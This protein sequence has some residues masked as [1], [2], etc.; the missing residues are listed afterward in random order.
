MPAA[1][2][3]FRSLKGNSSCKPIWN[4]TRSIW[5][6]ENVRTVW[7]RLQSLTKYIN[8]HTYMIIY[9]S[10]NCINRKTGCFFLSFLCKRFLPRNG[11]GSV[12]TWKFYWPRQV[13]EQRDIDLGLYDH[14]VGSTKTLFADSPGKQRWHPKNFF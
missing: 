8:R 9:A 10:V 14:Q 3:K 4:L 1:S 11:S 2:T 6:S 13:V 12:K 7:N 5:Y